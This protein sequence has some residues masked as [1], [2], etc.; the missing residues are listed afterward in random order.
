MRTDVRPKVDT[1]A[2]VDLERQGILHAED[3]GGRANEDVLLFNHHVLF[4]YAVARL[5]FLRG[6]QPDRLVS[7]LL[8]RRELSLMLSPSLTL[9]LSDAWNASPD[10]RQFWELALALG[11]ASA[12]PGVAQLAA[13]MVA[14]EQAKELSDLASILEALKGAGQQKEAAENVV[15]NMIGALFVRMRAGTPLVG[16]AAGPWMEFA[17]QLTGM[18]Q[19]RLMMAVR[20]LIANAVEAL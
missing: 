8:A 5:V 20:A 4:D 3:Q 14:V 18:G 15:R 10:H 16:P 9:A 13:S 1:D 12:L 19:D 17:E 7:L 11:Q 6:R 2:L